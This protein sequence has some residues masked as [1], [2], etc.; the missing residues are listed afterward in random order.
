MPGG[1]KVGRRIIK[2]IVIEHFQKAPG[3]PQYVNDL[4]KALSSSEEKIQECIAGIIRTNSLPGLTCEIRGRSWMYRPQA[5]EAAD[6]NP[7]KQLPARMFEEIGETR[8][9]SVII[10]DDAGKIYRAQEL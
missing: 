3:I 5:T 9:G 6:P 10:Q 4:A 2:P 7:R 8:D 1:G